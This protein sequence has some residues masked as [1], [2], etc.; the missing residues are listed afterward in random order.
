MLRDP[1]VVLPFCMCILLHWD[2]LVCSVSSSSRTPTPV[3]SSTM[4][5]PRTDGAQGY[6]GNHG[7]HDSPGEVA[8]I[9]RALTPDMTTAVSTT[10]FEV[11]AS[12]GSSAPT[13]DATAAVDMTTTVPIGSLISASSPRPQ[14]G[15]ATASVVTNVDIV[16]EHEVVL[17]HPLLRA[18]GMSPLVRQW[19]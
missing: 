17:G 13:P 5:A 14:M 10:T 6:T 2:S 16:E 12:D 15:A 18:Q 19:A 4:G 1:I 7:P 8:H 9:A 11:G 3:V